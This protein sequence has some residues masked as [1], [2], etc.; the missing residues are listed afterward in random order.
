MLTKRQQAVIIFSGGECSVILKACVLVILD[1]KTCK[2]NCTLYLDY[3]NTFFPT[4]CRSQPYLPTDGQSET[5]KFQIL[6]DDYDISP[7]A[8][9]PPMEF[10]GSLKTDAD[11]YGRG[12]SCMCKYLRYLL[13]ALVAFALGVLLGYGVAVERSSANEILVPNVI[14]STRAFSNTHNTTTV[15]VPGFATKAEAAKNLISQ[16][17]AG[18]NGEQVL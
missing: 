1:L 16:T 4:L 14:A 13:V 9:V 12:S 6:D 17:V 5:A 2:N 10:R 3:L 7:M 8:D 15:A 11:L 18:N